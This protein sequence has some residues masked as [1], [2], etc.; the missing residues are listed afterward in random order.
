MKMRLLQPD[1]TPCTSF[2]LSV[3]FISRRGTPETGNARR[4]VGG[5]DFFGHR[6]SEPADLLSDVGIESVGDRS[7][8]NLRPRDHG[9]HFQAAKRP[10][11]NQRSDR[12]DSLQPFDTNR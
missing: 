10:H 8:E 6:R 11:C 3:F 9:P 4:M 12:G 5:Y 1:E 7:V 2:P